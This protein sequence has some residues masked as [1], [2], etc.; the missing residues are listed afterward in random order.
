MDD[1]TIDLAKA[2]LSFAAARLS[3]PTWASKKWR[4][5]V[6]GLFGTGLMFIAAL[7]VFI[8]KP[9]VAGSVVGL[10]QVVVACWSAIV[11]AFI[12]AQGFVDK[13]TISTL[14][15]TPPSGQ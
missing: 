8:K 12:G 6:F 2:R 5:A 11:V 4:M 3:A 9:E 10:A 7:I 14:Q 1:A 13:E 15:P